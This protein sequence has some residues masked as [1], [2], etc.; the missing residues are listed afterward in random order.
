MLYWHPMG[1]HEKVYINDNHSSLQDD[2]ATDP[3][4]YPAIDPVTNPADNQHSNIL[5]MSI[6]TLEEYR[7]KVDK[8]Q[9]RKYAECTISKEEMVFGPCFYKIDEYKLR[10]AARLP[11]DADFI[12]TPDVK[13]TNTK[14]T[15]THIRI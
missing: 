2:P 14:K 8:N 10:I 15:I 7:K 1:A 5:E 11:V 6:I 12:I 13:K 9:S 3:V 4:T